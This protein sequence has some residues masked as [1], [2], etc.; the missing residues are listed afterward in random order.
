MA[1]LLPSRDSVSFHMNYLPSYGRSSFT[2]LLFWD[3]NVIFFILYG[4][5]AIRC[6]KSLKRSNGVTHCI[7]KGNFLRFSVYFLERKIQTFS[8]RSRNFEVLT[9]S[10]HIEIQSFTSMK[11]RFPL[12]YTRVASNKVPLK[13]VSSFTSTFITNT[14]GYL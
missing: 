3:T 5:F 4:K 1:S 13:I 11:K 2:P 9:S 7:R 14:F 6:S 8:K 12:E 10:P